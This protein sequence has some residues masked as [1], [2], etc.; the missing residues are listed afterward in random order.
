MFSSLGSG[1]GGKSLLRSVAMRWSV[2]RNTP[3]SIATPTSAEITDL[4]AD[5]MLTGVSNPGPPL[6]RSAAR[7][8]WTTTFTSVRKS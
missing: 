3:R 4:D 8:S 7:K 2:P 5:L 6:K 1:L